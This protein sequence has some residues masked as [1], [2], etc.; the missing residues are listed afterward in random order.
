MAENFKRVVAEFIKEAAKSAGVI[1][2]GD[3]AFSKGEKQDYDT[4]GS[5][6]QPISM[7]GL[8][9]HLLLGNHDDRDHFLEEFGTTKP[10]ATTTGGR[11]AAVVEGP[12]ANFDLLDTLE[13]VNGT[14]GLLAN[15]N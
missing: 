4:F 14:P 6:L 1:H 10:E 5:L 9:I 2:H 3:L 11:H 7:A 15:S 8:P 12:K 13:V